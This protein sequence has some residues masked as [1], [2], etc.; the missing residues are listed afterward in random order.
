MERKWITSSVENLERNV[1]EINVRVGKIGD[2]RVR[3]V[4]KRERR[5]A[6][7]G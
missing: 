2:K 5:Q 6:R 3:K 1:M 7:G 4:K